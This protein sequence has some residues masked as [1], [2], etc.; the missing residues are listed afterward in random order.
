MNS[1]SG[2]SESIIGDLV[3][4][5]DGF[6]GWLCLTRIS[7]EQVIFVTMIDLN[8]KSCKVCNLCLCYVVKS[9]FN[10]NI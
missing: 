9:F 7:E 8:C 10:E 3:N 6:D 2:K 1:D 5:S 4:P